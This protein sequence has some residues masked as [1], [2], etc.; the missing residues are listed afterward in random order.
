[1][2]EKIRQLASGTVDLPIPRLE[3]LQPKIEEMIAWGQVYRGDIRVFSGN[4]VDF[5]GL[6]YS[7]DSRIVLLQSSFAGVNAY[8]PYEVR[9]EQLDQGTVLEGHFCLVYNGGEKKLPYRFEVRR[10]AAG[11]VRQAESLEDFA[12]LARMRP[13]E[14][15]E[16]FDSQEFSRMPLMEDMSVRAI[17]DGLRRAVNRRNSLEEFLVAT[18]AKERLRLTVDETPRSFVL[19]DA[20]QTETIRIEKNTWGQV[21]IQAQSDNPCVI[22]NRETLTEKDFE[23]NVCELS[24]TVRRDRLHGGKNYA[25]ISLSAPLQSFQI[26]LTLAGRAEPSRSAHRRW[27]RRSEELEFLR[28]WLGTMEKDGD[29]K[30]SLEYLQY[31]WEEMTGDEEPDVHQKLYRVAISLGLGD[32]DMASMILEDVSKEV[33]ERRRED[34]DAYCAYL[35]LQAQVTESWEKKEQL[36]KI[37]HLYQDQGQET[38]FLFLLMLSM[39]EGAADRPTEILGRIRDYYRD[40]CR[41]PFL[42]LEACRI[43]NRHPDILKKLEHFELQ[44]LTFGARQ[45]IL[46]RETALYLAT[47]VAQERNYRPAF[48]RLLARLYDTYQDDEILEAVCALLIR[49]DRREAEDFV[50]FARG[51]ERD[52]R[53]TRLYDYYLYTVPEDWQQ[54]FPRELVLYFSYNSPR[55]PE[56][57]QLLYLN[58][59]RFY[60]NDRQIMQ[61][62]EEQIHSFVRCSILAGTINGELAHLYSRR[63]TVEDVDDKTARILPD[64]LRAHE[65]TDTTGRFAE[66]IVVY[67]ELEEELSVP[68][69][70]RRACVPL[71]SSSC[72]I[73]FADAAGTRYAGDIGTVR[74]LLE[75]TQSIENRCRELYSR[76]AMLR[77][78]EC[79]QILLHGAEMENQIRLLKKEIEVRDIHRQFRRAMTSAIVEFAIRR[80]KPEEEEL[81]ACVRYSGI[82]PDQRL[83]LTKL[84]I[85]LGQ[86]TEAEIQVRR[87]G[88]R[89]LPVGSLL[90]LVSLTIQN[91][92]Y[93]KDEFLVDM[94][95]YLFDRG[96]CD[97]ILLEY[98]CTYFNASSRE[99]LPILQ[100]AYERKLHTGDMPERLLGQMLFTGVYDGMDEVFH[101][102]MEQGNT[103]R[104]LVHA[105][106]VVKCSGYFLRQEATGEDVFHFVEGLLTEESERDSVPEICVLALTKYYAGR[107]NLTEEETRLCASLVDSLYRKGMIFAWMKDLSA[108]V[109]LPEEIRCREWLEYHGEAGQSLELRLRILPEME[110]KP[111]LRLVMPQIYPGIYVKSQLLFEGDEMEYEIVREDGREILEK[112]S[113]RGT[114]SPDS[115]GSRFARLN[116]LQAAVRDGRSV[117]AW[118]QEILDYAM[119]ETWTEQ[120]FALPEE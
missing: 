66:V 73:L 67:G 109:R 4:Q 14:A 98:L 23:K 37:L 89:E 28:T 58:L 90:R 72:R 91:S 63:L 71:Y 117:T 57:Q 54:A 105:Y 93:E 110:G 52:I 53:L 99:M 27:E 11:A 112:G 40:G 45:G 79:T 70:D 25:R 1:M 29:R 30:E 62:Y 44:T 20:E 13:E 10:S 46:T 74:P 95:R 2:K 88:Y 84:L 92:L 7:D 12:G 8:I 5:R 101:I 24:F 75:N 9:A 102:Y 118:Q 22:L 97:D 77:L 82:T 34:T 81:L 6:I 120:I 116:R 86:L 42:Y 119:M 51:V 94:C 100:M 114:A 41:S 107:E 60:G 43:Y 115:D 15:R 85:D 26:D 55:N 17:Y 80:E 76:H 16:L 59:I 87:I 47:L 113:R 106:F 50:W 31:C 104:L 18:G 61:S 103:D 78:A 33:E 108:R 68:L 111:P 69:R 35:Y 49:G 21:R 48:H 19:Q 32:T 36:L 38:V 96:Q 65:I 39:D 64:I 3:L 83:R 56:S